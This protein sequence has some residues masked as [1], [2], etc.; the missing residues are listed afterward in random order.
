MVPVDDEPFRL[1]SAP[2][3]LGLPGKDELNLAEFPIASVTDRVP[4]GQKTL[5][6][7][8][9]IYDGREGQ[10]ITRRLVITASDEYGLPTAKDDEIILGLVQLTRQANNFTERTVRFGRSDLIGLLAWPDTGP[11]YRRLALSFHRWLGV[12]LHYDN[13]W[14]DKAQQA[15]STLGFHILESFKLGDGGR[16]CGRREQ[17]PSRFTWNEDVFRSF[18]AGY[19]KQLDLAFYLGLAHPTAKRMYR[20]LDKRFYHRDRWEF[21]LEEFVLDHIGLSRTYEGNAQLARKLR[22]AIRELEEK[23]FLEPL[24]PDE[25]FQKL[26]PRRWR[27]AFVRQAGVAEAKTHPVSAMVAELTARGVT[28][29]TAEELVAAFPEV[30]VRAKLEI[31]DWL[32]DRK[33]GRAMHSP[34]GFLVQSIREDYAP[35][36]GFESQV[37]RARRLAAERDR[38]RRAEEARR[39]RAAE[40][41]G[42]E[43]AKQA[44]IWSYWESLPP[45]AQDRLWEEALAGALPFLVGRYRRHRGRD[46]GLERRYRKLILEAHILDLLERRAGQGGETAGG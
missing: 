17:S 11:S 19:L 23:G 31:L 9:R 12:S 16:A 43:Q 13:A 29:S 3:P 10:P 27:V 4:A 45:D 21:D 42:H 8:D 39:L 14:W 36:E 46:G 22:P 1:L 28:A 26:S 33:D 34:A 38:A 25:R 2:T 35:P 5:R 44:R 32:L 24:G 30:R 6:F 37:D 40:E 7:E 20:F 15:W 18:Q 41:R